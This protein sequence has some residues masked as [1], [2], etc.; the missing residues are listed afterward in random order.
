M[1]KMRFK[2]VI[3]FFFCL[4]SA[5]GIDD[6]VVVVKG[7]KTDYRLLVDHDTQ[8]AGELLQKYLQQI[9][10]ALL[11]ISRKD[12]GHPHIKL[13]IDES[14]G[15]AIDYQINDLG[16]I[17]IASGDAKGLRHA[18]Y[19]FL[20]KELGCRWFTPME[21]LIPQKKTLTFHKDLHHHYQPPI[22]TRTVHS[23][24][25]YQNP[26]FAEKHKVT[27]RAF[28]KYVPIARVHTF[29]RMVPEEQFYKKH[30][31]YFALRAGKRLPTQL[32]LTNAKVLSIVKD[33]VAAWFERYPKSEV[34]SVSQDDNQQYCQCEQCAAI[35]LEEQSHAG[36]MI[37]FVNQVAKAFP[38]KTISTL[39]YQHTR[40][41][42]KTKPVPNVLITLCSIECDR[43]ASIGQ[44]CKDFARDLNGW[45]KLTKNIRI[46]DY[47]TQFTNFLA[48]FPN[49]HTLSPNIKLFLKNNAR[50][51]FEQHSNNPSE[52]F[53][54]RSYLMAKLLW[55][56]ESDS[57]SIID[58]FILGYYGDAGKH[59]LEYVST[60][61]QKIKAYPN[62]FLFL[63][64]D[65]SQAFKTYLS[66]KDLVVYDKMFD[67]AAKAVAGDEVLSNRVAKARLGVDFAILEAFK[68]NLSGSFSMFVESDKGRRFVHPTLEKKLTSFEET[69]QKNDILM[70]NEMG[71]KV[72]VYCKQYRTMLD[73]K[74]IPNKA[75]GKKV[76]LRTKPHKY[77]DENPQVLTDGAL[78]GYNFYANWLGFE[79]NHLEAIVD[80]GEEQ[81][82][83]YIHTGFLKVT[84]HVVFYPLEVT[85]AV[86]GRDKK[87]KTVS[88]QYPEP[89]TKKSKVNDIQYLPAQFK[90]V[91]A[92]YVKVKA[93]NCLTPPY[94]H[95]AAG[96]P[97]WIFI[98]EIIVH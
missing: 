44:K 46:W 54:L 83:S 94:W 49:L 32:C 63:Y 66:A 37:R 7:G 86:A 43:S 16:N 89:L 52:L 40:T 30:P 34:L 87:F 45:G 53:E 29:H 80:L 84:N 98:D 27:Q 97:A 58:D 5:C 26:T 56:P 61:H 35:D 41:P 60:I 65:P 96:L 20:E 17:S 19:E 79:G 4:I 39:A 64:G 33:S 10:G 23:R 73:L 93:K 22:T 57:Q 68:N 77:A 21:E 59:I 72:A 69:C 67:R 31:E 82:I 6:R 13:Y 42:P 14:L 18:V 91:K 25:F 1:L 28:P 75:Q 2:T 8:E 48:P 36:T 70:M 38:N 62:F 51:I 92:R 9:T 11:P 71:L 50:W 85:Y 76:T 3:F 47:T 88:K 24:L 90:S 95:H 78:G 55:N 81:N 74:T 15:V 12:G